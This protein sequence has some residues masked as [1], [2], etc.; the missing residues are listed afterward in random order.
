MGRENR[1]IPPKMFISPPP[2]LGTRPLRTS[3]QGIAYLKPSAFGSPEASPPPRA[4]HPLSSEAIWANLH[5]VESSGPFGGPLGGGGWS[6][7]RPIVP[8]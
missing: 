5:S 1:A 2:Q 8:R 7:L 4:G 6:G 3:R